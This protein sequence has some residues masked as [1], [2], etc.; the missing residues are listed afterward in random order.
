MN[1]A[2]TGRSGGRSQ[3]EFASLNLS[4][5]VG[6]AHD[7]VIGNQ[8][9][10]AALV[11]AQQWCTLDARHGAEVVV[12][13]GAGSATGADGVVTTQR[14]LALLALAADCLPIVLADPAAGVIAAAH[15]GWRGLTAGIIAATVNRM[16]DMGAVRIRAVSGPAICW[17]CYPV[18]IDCIEAL[19]AGLPATV[20]ETCTHQV[21]GQWFVD[22]RAGAH[23]QLRRLG[24]DVHAINRCTFEDSRLFSYRRDGRTG[25]QGM[26]IVQ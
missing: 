5:T 17:R 19:Q 11:D 22:V 24:V 3:D 9:R 1:W 26:I 23:A 4:P 25:R 12:A 18:R 10:A 13:S 15:C 7:A 2:A 20:F 14:G 8:A 16:R 21:G 6:D